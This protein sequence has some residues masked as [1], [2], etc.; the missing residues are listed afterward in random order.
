M[1][2]RTSPTRTRRVRA[3]SAGASVAAAALLLAGCSTSSSGAEST[4]GAA[5]D[6][7]PF[8][9]AMSWISN[10]E[11]G[12]FWLAAENGY[13]EDEGL[14]VE[15]LPGGPDA[16]TAESQVAADAADAG[17][18]AGMS[19]AFA[20][21]ADDDF[22]IIGSV[23]QDNPGCFLWLKDDPIET[24]DDLVGKTILAQSEATVEQVLTLNDIPLDAVT[25]LPTGFDPAPLVNGDGDVYTAYATNQPITMELTFGLKPDVDFGCTLSGE[26]GAPGY[27]SS[28]FAKDDKID[29]NRD[30]YVK[31][32]RASVKG[33]QDF[34][35]DPTSGAELAV[36][37]F[38]ADLGLD[39][40]QQTLSGEAFAKLMESPA[41][42]EHGLLYMDLDR[43]ET[44]MYP[45]L[46][47]S[48]ITDLPP[49]DEAVDLSLLDEIEAK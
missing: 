17:I 40:E 9:V 25:I 45:A 21:M 37:D 41:T 38:G 22:S 26:L 34:L 49:V 3:L 10:V 24:A 7:I 23:F 4:D 15:W 36:N 39:L 2:P 14:D 32:L 33:W 48:G 6:P 44:E 29:E 27:A 19:S 42:D 1:V 18:T 13:Y 35:A 43:L 12:G 8:S 16:P 30:A 46:E 47:A 11:Y 28:I 20:A 5:A 31:F